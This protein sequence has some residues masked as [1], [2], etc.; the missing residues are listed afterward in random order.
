MAW[1]KLNDIKKTDA[2][3]HAK[4]QSF[5]LLTSNLLQ[6]KAK[7]FRYNGLTRNFCE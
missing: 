4:A 5:S 2:Q 7:L 6:L 1:C 3:L